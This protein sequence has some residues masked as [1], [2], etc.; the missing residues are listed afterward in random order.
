MASEYTSV[1]GSAG[2]VPPPARAHRIVAVSFT[3]AGAKAA[4]G[5]LQLSGPG[6]PHRHIRAHR[7]DE[8]TLA[9]LGDVVQGSKIGVHLVFS[10][11]QTDIYAARAQALRNGAI[12]AE[13]TLLQTCM[14]E[15]NVFCAHCKET[16]TTQNDVGATFVCSG[17]AR[18][19]VIYHHFSRRTA[20]YLG[21]MANAEETK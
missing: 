21:F 7:A 4:Q 18:E 14:T 20:S 16:T 2:T 9:D 19:L 5:W 12:D 13:I 15:A 1:P 10:G 3:A 8:S 17:C 11:P 6:T